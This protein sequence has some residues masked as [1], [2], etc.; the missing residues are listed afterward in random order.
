MVEQIA[1]GLLAA[2]QLNYFQLGWMTGNVEAQVYARLAL[3]HSAKSLGIDLTEEFWNQ[4]QAHMSR[5]HAQLVSV[6]NDDLD[7][8]VDVDKHYRLG[9]AVGAMD[10][11]QI[12][13]SAI[14]IEAASLQL[15][16]E[17]WKIY[18]ECLKLSYTPDPGIRGW[19][20]RLTT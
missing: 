2:V 19:L 4:Y 17:F 9:K 1:K 3:K 12:A 14:R 8:D 13:C 20:D 5:A 16:P 6:D 10:A 11:H 7:V 18:T 15:T